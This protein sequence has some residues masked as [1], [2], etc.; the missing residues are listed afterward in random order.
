MAGDLIS[1][2][3]GKPYA[4]I[5]DDFLKSI[6]MEKSFV[7]QKGMDLSNIAQMSN[8]IIR[9]NGDMETFNHR[10]LE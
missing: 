4:H 10:L 7:V 1:K 6:G 8:G 3:A 2:L 5:M 9:R